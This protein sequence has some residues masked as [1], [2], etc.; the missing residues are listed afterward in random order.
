MTMKANA[1]LGLYKTGSYGTPEEPIRSSSVKAAFWKGY[2]GQRGPAKGTI[3]HEA[4]LAG[5][6]VAKEKHNDQ[7]QD[8]Y[9]LT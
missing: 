8:D 7:E 9:N 3:N 4:Y 1:V 2:F 6:A 5:K